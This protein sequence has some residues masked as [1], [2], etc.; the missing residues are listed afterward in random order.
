MRRGLI[1]AGLV[2]VVLVGALAVA[3]ANLGRFLGAHRDTLAARAARELGRPVELGDLTV[4]LRGGPGVRIAGV[5]VVEDPEWGGGDLLRADEVRVTVRLVPALVGRFEISRVMLRRPVL[6]VIRDQRGWNLAT[7]GRQ[8]AHAAPR[9]QSASRDERRRLALLVGLADVRDGEV[10]Y[11]DRRREPALELVARHVAASLS[12]VAADRPIGVALRAALFGAETV[13]LD[14]TGSVGPFDDPPVPAR[15]PLDLRW[16][17]DDTD[18]AA[19]VR[20]APLLDAAMPRE[21]I[22]AGPLTAHGRVEG[23]LDQLAGQA[24]LDA[25]AAAIRLGTA[26]AKAPDVALTAALDMRRAADSLAVRRGVVELG[27]ATLDVM[28]T[29]RPG[30]PPTVD[31]RLAS[32]HAPLATLASL[33]PATAA[34]HA[35]GTIEAQLTVQGAWRAHPP[36][37]VAGT[38][39]LADVWA[40]R[41]GDRVGLSGLTATVTVGDGVARMPATRF[42]VGGSPVE[43]SGTFQIADRLLT[44]DG[45][46]REVFGGTV[47]GT[48]RME[49]ADPKHPRFAI[50]GTA[51]GVALAPLLAGRESPLAAHVEGRLDADVS[52]AAAGARRRAVRRSLTGTARIDVRDGVL[53]GV[54]IVDEV[55]GAVTGVDQAGQ[56]VPARLRRKRPELFGGADTKFEELRATARIADR[57]ASTDDLVLRTESYTVTGRGRVSFAGDTD[58]TA[59]F[60]AG[61]AL[62]ADVLESVKDARW[63]L[64]AEHRVAVP[65]R[66]AGRF[67]DLRLRPDPEFVARV[68]GRALEARAR[69]ALGGDRK[70]DRQGGMVGDAIRRLQQFLGR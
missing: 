35:G 5:R 26:F 51:R 60:V 1:A 64:N 69:K 40:R 24:A 39:A 30:D 61:P 46:S 18:A 4:S 70:D 34:A 43:A 19:L 10:R 31:L 23:R 20:A 11:L 29:I 44:V 13:N 52:L 53:R 47:A 36:P 37:V 33:V 59:T 25:S 6:T 65:F 8:R 67:P 9:S 32:N 58:L 41:H 66:V 21:L 17:L 48:G 2:V 27:D 22:V 14:V 28:G 16:T 50:D 12:D 45:T 62:T 49:L 55:L 68:V 57:H 38:V 63:V 56:L 42:Q 3:M 15:T 54:K 7:L